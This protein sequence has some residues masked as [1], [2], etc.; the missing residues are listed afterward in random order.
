MTHQEFD[1]IRYTLDMAMGAGKAHP[2]IEIPH[3]FAARVE[4]EI[5]DKY[6]Q[7]EEEER[8]GYERKKGKKCV[9]M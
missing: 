9:V 4:E 7:D 5:L 2:R 8:T 1:D 3:D 6:G